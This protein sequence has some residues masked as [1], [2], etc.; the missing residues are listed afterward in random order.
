[1]K[2]HLI[3]AAAFLLILALPGSI[4]A[5]DAGLKLGT[6]S[7][8]NS[9]DESAQEP[10]LRGVRLLHSF[11]YSD[12]ATAFR[13]AQEADPDF[14]MAYWGEAMTYNHP[15]WFDHDRE[16]AREALERL[17]PTREQ[18]LAKAG[19]GKER[20]FLDAVETLYG[21][22]ELYDRNRAYRDAMRRMYEQHPDDD[23]VATFYAL[24][25]LGTSEAGRDFATYMKAA[26]I[27]DVV[28]RRNPDHPGAAHYLIHSFDDPIHAPLGLLAARSYSEIAPDAAHALHMPT[29]I[30]VALG[31]WQDVAAMNVRSW[32]ASVDRVERLDLS[33]N[34]YS[35]HAIHWE[36]YARTQLGQYDKAHELVEK[37]ASLY[38]EAG[39]GGIHYY[40]ARMIATY[41]TDSEDWAYGLKES[42]VNIENLNLGTAAMHEFAR[43]YAAVQTG[44]VARTEQVIA[45]MRE[46]RTEEAAREDEFDA[47]S[48]GEYRQGLEVALVLEKELEALVAQAN[49]DVDR[50]IET[51]RQARDI[52]TAM[53]FDYGPPYIVKPA[54]ELLGETLLAAERFEEA[55]EAF[56]LSLGRTPGRSPSLA[57]LA[58]AARAAGMT[59]R[60]EEAEAQLAENMRN[61][62][63]PTESA[64]MGASGK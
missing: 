7:F 25:I 40:L 48:I 47:A 35:Y 37:V 54:P 52:E 6:V 50:A 38:A 8:P 62:D 13:E 30:F 14:A 2:R 41:I 4:L 11:E 21:D 32:Q 16:D 22:G 18:R 59:D 31:M 57:G 20:E 58:E 55:V 26:S 51:L 53:S 43:A 3:P 28:F 33:P 27:A 17:A 56:E 29:H 1:M 42:P 63:E 10:F 60:A 12:A 46:R 5:Q 64:P 23:E 34:A 39:G 44:D 15:L 19:T 9:G 61:A 36:L 45:G 49:G 24:S